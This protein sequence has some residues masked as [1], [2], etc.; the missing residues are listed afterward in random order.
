MVSLHYI[1][2]PFGYNLTKTYYFIPYRVYFIKI[3]IFYTRNDIIFENNFVFL[4]KIN[5]YG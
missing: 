1:L 5:G 4:Q 3:F 2:Y